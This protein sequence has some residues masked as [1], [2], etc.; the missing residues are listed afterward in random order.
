MKKLYIGNLPWTSTE[1]DLRDLFSGFG[2]VH[3][4]AV[5]TDRD[6]GRSRGFGFVELDEAAA[7]KAISDLDGKDYGGRP[8]RVNE[9]QQRERGPS[10]DR[11]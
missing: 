10:R 3:S 1:A 11:W 4:A 2:E 6:T 8:I 9:A 5:I 7:D